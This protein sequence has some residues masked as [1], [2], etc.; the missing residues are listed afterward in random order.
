MKLY[1]EYG[2]RAAHHP[3]LHSTCN[4]YTIV[5]QSSRISAI[6]S[7]LDLTMHESSIV[8]SSKL[9]VMVIPQ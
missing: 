7:T 5:I 9:Y 1:K 3:N 4:N 2:D 6:S 8:V